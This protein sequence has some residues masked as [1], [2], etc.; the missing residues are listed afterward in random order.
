[1]G[2]LNRQ[3]QDAWNQ[4]AAWWDEK[5]G[6]GN[7]SQRTL[8]GPATE[9]LL[10]LQPGDLVLDCACGN[11][12]FSRRMAQ[13]G[14][15]VVAFDF[16]ETFLERAKAR[17]TEHADR[18]EYRLINATDEA[19]LLALGTRRFDAAVCTMGLM[20]MVTIEPLLSALRQLLTVGSHF[21]FSVL[22]PCFNSATGLK[23][24]VEEEDKN[25]ELITVYS[26]KVSEY[27]Q[28]STAKGLGIV[29]QPVPH[30]YFHRPLSVLFNTCFRAGFV[31][32]GME[33][34]TFNQAADPNRPLS[35]QNFAEIPPFL[36]ARM[37]LDRQQHEH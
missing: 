19:Q 7:L 23:R 25:G 34:P 28:P 36:V 27:I 12:A 29:G 22:H 35:R 14:A 10:N 21:V 15:R 37:R 26:V 2:T 11:G 13:L 33:E 30:Y 31:L 32:D 1:M 24:V 18:I 9:Q 3:T 6:E 16:S 20:D 17:T 4:N 5:T 8:I